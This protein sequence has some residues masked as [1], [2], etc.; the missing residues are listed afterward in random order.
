MKSWDSIL[1]FGH[2]FL[3]GWRC[4]DCSYNFMRLAH[5]ALF[6]PF[7]TTSRWK[8]R[9]HPISPEMLAR[10]HCFKTNT[11]NSKG[12]W[13]FS[14]ATWWKFNLRAPLI[15]APLYWSWEAEKKRKE[16]GAH[17]ERNAEFPLPAVRYERNVYA[18]PIILGAM[19]E[20]W[21]PSPHHHCST[22]HWTP[23]LPPF[24]N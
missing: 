18:K 7:M 21:R 14:L 22:L 23:W 9:N 3:L 8:T 17:W 20:G 24:R 10:L 5:D 1:H 4:K 15:Y 6:S 13:K 16:K 12:S 2:A 19:K 11:S